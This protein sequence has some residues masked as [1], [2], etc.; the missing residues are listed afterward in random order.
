MSRRRDM[1][2]KLYRTERLQLRIDRIKRRFAKVLRLD[3]HLKMKRLLG[4]KGWLH[5]TRR[6]SGQTSRNA[7]RNT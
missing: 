2:A 7:V 5:K 6:A 3:A 4:P 1:T